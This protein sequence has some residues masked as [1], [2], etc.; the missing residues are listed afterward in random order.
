MVAVLTTM[1]NWVYP[2]I[3]EM[4]HWSGTGGWPLVLDNVHNAFPVSVAR[5]KVAQTFLA[6]KLN[7]ERLEWLLMIDNDMDPPPDLLDVLLLPEMADK[8]IVSMKCYRISPDWNGIDLAWQPLTGLYSPR[9]WLPL[10]RAGTGAIFIRRKVLLELIPP[11]FHIGLKP[12]GSIAIGE[13]FYFSDKARNAGF[14]I[15]GLDDEKYEVGHIKPVNLSCIAPALKRMGNLAVPEHR[16]GGEGIRSRKEWRYFISKPE[17]PPEA[18]RN[19]PCPCGS[20][21]KFKNCCL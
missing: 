21:R 10:F 19:D 11:W 14:Q 13:D 3:M 18:G 2:S 4:V 16:L 8:D 17:N 20:G 6:S 9:P 5:N 12:D 7:G 15:W 1:T